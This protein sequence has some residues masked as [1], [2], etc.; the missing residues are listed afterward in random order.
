MQVELYG[1]SETPSYLP[2][3]ASF[4]VGYP[5]TIQ[6]INGQTLTVS[7]AELHD[8][9][10]AAMSVHPNPANCGTTCYALIPTTGLHPATTY[11]VH[12]AGNV[13]G[14]AF[15]KTWS[16]TTKTCANPLDC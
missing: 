5:I 6:P 2:P 8:G 10:G 4:P 1:T 12:I 13:D 9:N 7:Q 3:G 15:D 16:F 14:I 11:T